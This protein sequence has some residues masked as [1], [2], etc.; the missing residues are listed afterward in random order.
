[1]TPNDR[2]ALP[3]WEYED[4]VRF[5]A[6]FQ[7]FGVLYDINHKDRL[8]KHKKKDALRDLRIQLIEIGFQIPSEDILVK[9]IKN[10][11]D[12]FA[13]ELK[14]ELKQLP[15]GSAAPSRTQFRSKLEWYNLARPFWKSS[16]RGRASTSNLVSMF[17]LFLPQIDCWTI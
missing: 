7:Q 9:K 12:A 11:R 10:L 1:M 5:F 17:Y 14:E 4:L 8:N 6:L 15:S 2:T 16:I 13:R 3:K